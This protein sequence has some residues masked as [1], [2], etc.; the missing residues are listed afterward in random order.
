MGF[1]SNLFKSKYQRLVEESFVQRLLLWNGTVLDKAR[2]GR[3]KKLLAAEMEEYY[4]LHDPKDMG[5]NE[6]W[7]AFV[8]RNKKFV[9]AASRKIQELSRE[10]RTSHACS[11]C[12][13]TVYTPDPKNL[14]IDMIA[15]AVLWCSKCNKP[16]CMQCAPRGKCP[17]GGTVD[18]DSVKE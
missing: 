7:E 9:D 1:F 13:K 17:C 12:G 2:E 15:A 14:S 10:G 5:S 4:R 8:A 18:A 3:L 16:F 6:A 11:K